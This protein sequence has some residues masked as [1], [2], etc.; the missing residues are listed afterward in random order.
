MRKDW[1]A[2]LKRGDESVIEKLLPYKAVLK[3]CIPAPVR[4]RVKVQLVRKRIQKIAGHNKVEKERSFGVNVFGSVSGASGL[5]EASRGVVA[6]L[7]EAGI[8]VSIWDVANN[9][10]N[11]EKAAP[12]AVN[13]MHVNPNQLP[14]L[15]YTI[16][17]KQWEGRY[18]IGFWVWEQENLPNEWRTF[19]PLFDEIW[20]PSEF[21]AAAIRRATNLPVIVVPHVVAPVY[22]EMFDRKAFGLPDDVFLALLAFDCNSVV[23]RK[24]PVGAI[25]ALDIAFPEEK[26]RVGIIIK[27]RNMPDKMREELLK[28]LHGW[29]NVFFLTGDYSKKEMNSLIRVSDI[30]VSLHRAEGFGLILAEAM[31]LET[32]VIATNWSGNTEFMDETVACMVNADLVELKQDYPPFKKGSRWAEPDIRQAAKYVRQLYQEP[33]L[34]KKLAARARSRIQ[35]KLSVEEISRIVKERMEIIRLNME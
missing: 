1:K 20:T 31:Y 25:K 9:V 19:L 24:N 6:C 17:E 8:P 10:Q 16:P 4:E 32:P 7:R 33:T 14:E 12:Y 35:H 26:D 22:D 2:I 15:L 27:A 21:S 18:N 28:Q 29:K 5:S 30:Y 34:R 23:E 13:L 11:A 3:R